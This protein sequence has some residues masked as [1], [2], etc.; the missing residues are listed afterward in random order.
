MSWFCPAF[1]WRDSNLYLVFSVFTS[2][3][4][5]LLASTVQF[6]SVFY[7]GS[8]VSCHNFLSLC[9][10]LSSLSRLHGPRLRS[11]IVVVLVDSLYAEATETAESRA[12]LLFSIHELISTLGDTKAEARLWN[13]SQF[14]NFSTKSKISLTLIVSRVFVTETGFVLVIGFINHS[15]VV[16]TNNYYTVPDLHNSLHYN[17]LSLFPLAFTLR[18]LAK[19]LNTGIIAFSIFTLHTNQSF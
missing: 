5:S 13:R 15:Q 6:T 7:A 12:A 14:V 2:R 19:D 4:T 10:C 16:T 9:L 1:W 17:L 18:F 8:R 3:P 11:K